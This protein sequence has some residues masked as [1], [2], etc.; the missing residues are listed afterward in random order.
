MTR[1]PI[2]SDGGGSLFF[3]ASLFGAKF[4]DFLFV[5]RPL[6]RLVGPCFTALGLA[7]LVAGS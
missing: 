2:A 4:R 6:M 5:G 7:A 3:P 1:V